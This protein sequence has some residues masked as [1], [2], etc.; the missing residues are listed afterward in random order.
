MRKWPIIAV[1]NPLIRTH[2]HYTKKIRMRFATQSEGIRH[3]WLK[4]LIFLNPRRGGSLG[5]GLTPDGLTK[6]E[7]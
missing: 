1:T 2:K 5:F 3:N 7:R 6:L 4:L